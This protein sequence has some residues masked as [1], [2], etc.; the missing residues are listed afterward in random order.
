MRD[1]AERLAWAASAER[2]MAEDDNLPA[3]VTAVCGEGSIDDRWDEVRN[4]AKADSIE[5]C[6]LRTIRYCTRY[7]SYENRRREVK[8]WREEK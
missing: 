5:F 7:L 2:K 6:V 4:E 8:K 1:A 3:I